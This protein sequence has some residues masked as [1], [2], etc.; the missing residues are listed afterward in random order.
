MQFWA[1][2]FF[3]SWWTFSRGL[4]F[5][6]SLLFNIIRAATVCMLFSHFESFLLLKFIQ[7][8][9]SMLMPHCKICAF[10][11]L[12]PS[13]YSLLH[14]FAWSF[15]VSVTQKDICKQSLNV[16]KA[17]TKHFKANRGHGVHE[18]NDSVLIWQFISCL[19]LV[20]HLKLNNT[21][22]IIR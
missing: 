10:L 6:P 15:A 20:L 5:I 11:M 2:P 9:R 8:E 7:W 12:K 13:V 21:M 18:V 14:S 22:W 16:I 1:L 19:P 4:N 3:A 17:Q